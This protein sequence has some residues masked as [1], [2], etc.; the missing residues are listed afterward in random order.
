ME[1]TY[2]LSPHELICEIPGCNK[3]AVD[4]HHI[5]G[6]GKYPKLKDDIKNL[7]GLCR[8]H[9]EEFGQKKQFIEYLQNITNGR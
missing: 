9:H 1:S 3:I 8:E 5:L 6:K 7:I 2:N 4:V